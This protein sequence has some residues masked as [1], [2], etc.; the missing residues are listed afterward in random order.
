HVHALGHLGYNTASNGLTGH[1]SRMEIEKL[2][3]REIA[4]MAKKFDSIPEG[5][6]SMLDNTMIVYM[7][8]SS[9]DHHCEGHDWPFVLLGGMSKK[10]KMGRYLEYPKYG[11]QGHQTVGSLYLSLMRA[12]GLETSESF[13]QPDSNL[14]HLTLKGPLS[15]LMA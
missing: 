15:E 13:G 2:H 8:C 5:N 4:K 1:Q 12:A 11:D 6:G 7:S 9:G 14:K 3:L 10:I